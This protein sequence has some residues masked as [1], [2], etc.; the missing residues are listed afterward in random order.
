MPRF[1][2]KYEKCK[3]IFKWR[4]NLLKDDVDDKDKNTVDD[5]IEGIETNNNRTDSNSYKNCLEVNEKIEI[6]GE[7]Y[8]VRITFY[9]EKMKRINKKEKV[10]YTVPIF[11]DIISVKGKEDY[12]LK[13]N[14]QQIPNQR[15]PV[16]DGNCTVIVEKKLG[17]AYFKIFCNYK[18][19]WVEEEKLRK[20]LRK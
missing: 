17:Q 2:D 9:S 20:V 18:N 1:K 13:F 10:M 8:E 4:S 15:C 14:G 19:C 16:C 7:E 6:R 3:T 11:L 12:F 5:L